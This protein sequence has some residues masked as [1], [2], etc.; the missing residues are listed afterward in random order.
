MNRKFNNLNRITSSL[1]ALILFTLAIACNPDD[2]S[3]E[4][5]PELITRVVLTFKPALG[6][7]DLVFTATDPDGEGV[8]DLQV[9]G[10]IL[11]TGGKKY[12]LEIGLFNDLA[13]QGSPAYDIGSEVE[14]EGDEHLLLFK[15]TNEIFMM[16]DGGGNIDNRNNPVIY[17]D[18]DDAGLPL[19]LRTEWT[20]I[21]GLTPK[22]GDF[23]IV[24]KHQPGTKTATS[25]M[26]T[27]ETDLDITFSCTVE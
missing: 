26:E 12:Q 18:T 25:G 17:L 23:R 9:S 14:E 16:P 3:K 21:S 7:P 27:G 19:G 2:P 8:Q 1:F 10:P 6:G 5:A 20:T 13:E 15:W 24:L 22:T 11:L 4:N